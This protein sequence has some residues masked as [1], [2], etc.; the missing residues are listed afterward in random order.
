MRMQI[1]LVSILSGTGLQYTQYPT[2][3]A[4]GIL[5]QSSDVTLL[6]PRPQCPSVER[7]AVYPAGFKDLG[8]V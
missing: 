7:P 8:W 1:L 5:V 2:R 4:G 6:T 3:K